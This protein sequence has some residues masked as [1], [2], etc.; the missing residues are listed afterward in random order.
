M[1]KS[2]RTV[3]CGR[4][5]LCA[6]TGANNNIFRLSIEIGIKVTEVHCTLKCS[7]RLP[8]II[9]DKPHSTTNKL[10]PWC[11]HNFNLGR[12]PLIMTTNEL[13]K[14][15]VI[16]PLKNVHTIWERTLE[17]VEILL[18]SIAVPND[19]IRKEIDQMIQ[20]EYTRQTSRNVLGTMNDFIRLCKAS[21]Y[22]N[23]N[24]SLEEMSLELSRVPCGPRKYIFPY[25]EALNI[26][27]APATNA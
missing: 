1:F 24:G 26:L 21:Y 8:I 27:T 13:T 15:T 12:N 9:T 4:G 3:A 17:S 19:V 2:R 20:V 23:T 22:M 10:G 6:I 16:V 14:L 25:K 7:K 18:H 5:K 11:S